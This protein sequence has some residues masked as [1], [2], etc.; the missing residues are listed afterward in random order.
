LKPKGFEIDKDV[1]LLEIKL[2][3]SKGRDYYESD[4]DGSV[5]EK[6]PNFGIIDS[7]YIDELSTQMGMYHVEDEK[8]ETDFVMCLM[9]GIAYIVKKVPN[10][11]AKKGSLNPLGSYN[12]QINNQ[13]GRI[14]SS[15]HHN[16]FKH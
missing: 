5:I 3:M 10:P 11:N 15:Q 8:L 12:A 9:M 7:Y 6:N 13:S 4:I 14:I 1:A 16:F 2:A